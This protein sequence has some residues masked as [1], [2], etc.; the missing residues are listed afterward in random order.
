MSV[1]S[2]APGF[3]SSMEKLGVDLEQIYS[4]P[5]ELLSHTYFVPVCIT[6]QH[7]AFDYLASFGTI[8]VG[9]E[10]DTLTYCPDFI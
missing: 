1:S 4:S 7:R 2:L 10:E 5:T 8:F 9:K 6:W 3:L